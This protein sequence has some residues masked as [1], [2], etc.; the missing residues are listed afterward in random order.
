VGRRQESGFTLVES[1]ISATL[2]VSGV[3]LITAALVRSKVSRVETQQQAAAI[4]A[5]EEMSA[6]LR[7]MSCTS[8]YSTYAPT[9]Q[10]APFPA[11]G[12][13]PGSAIAGDGLCD[14]AAPAQPALVRVRFHTDE[15]EAAPTVGLPRDLDGDGAVSDVNTAAAGAGGEILARILPYTLSITY[16][17]PQGG[18]VTRTL[19]GMI[20]YV[21]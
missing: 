18:S 14:P 2:M 11:A 8:A 17:G 15:T 12:S 13:G 16:R 1:L 3:L 4:S 9:P 6:R 5:L 21:R 20:T 10:G 19:D 7:T